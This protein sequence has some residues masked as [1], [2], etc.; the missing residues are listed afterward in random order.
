MED[1]SGLAPAPLLSWNVQLH[2]ALDGS[3]ALHKLGV[4]LGE[5]GVDGADRDRDIQMLKVRGG[6]GDVLRETRGNNLTVAAEDWAWARLAEAECETPQADIKYCMI[7]CN[8][9]G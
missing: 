1:D 5:G 8:V 2:V 9:T 7:Y 4:G 6:A 3:K